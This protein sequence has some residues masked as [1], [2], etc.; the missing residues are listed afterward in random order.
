MLEVSIPVGGTLLNEVI[1]KC[2]KVIRD[3]RNEN[4]VNNQ[5]VSL[6]S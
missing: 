1:E 5:I 6:K 2:A 4:Q 3:D